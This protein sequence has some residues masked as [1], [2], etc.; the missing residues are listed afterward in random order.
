MEKTRDL[1]NS[2]SL[3]TNTHSGMKAVGPSVLTSLSHI[4]GGKPTHASM[5][6]ELTGTPAKA[7]AEALGVG[8]SYPMMSYVLL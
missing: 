2:V 5:Y 6:T 8:P 1:K 7:L 4:D 3:T